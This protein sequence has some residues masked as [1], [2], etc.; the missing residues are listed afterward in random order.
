[1]TAKAAEAGEGSLLENANIFVRA[2]ETESD[3]QEIVTVGD[4]QAVVEFISDGSDADIGGPPGTGNGNDTTDIPT[5]AG[6]AVVDG[7]VIVEI[8]VDGEVVE[9]IPLREVLDEDE[10]DPGG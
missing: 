5:D 6:L 1:M 8:R 9:R 3:E 4:R 2:G 10:N 7:E